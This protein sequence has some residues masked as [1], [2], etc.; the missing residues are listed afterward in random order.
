M[1]EHLFPDCRS[2]SQCW[3]EVFRNVV[4]NHW[5]LLD[6]QYEA[7]IDLVRSMAKNP[8]AALGR[9][10]ETTPERGGLETTPPHATTPERGGNLEEAAVECVERGLPPP[11]AVY[12]VQNRNRIDWTRLPEWARP[13]DPDLFE[14]ASHEG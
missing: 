3:S 9:G 1:V 7:G 2:L 10:L 5:K 6:A 14:G 11:R 4:W 13:A 12:E 8:P